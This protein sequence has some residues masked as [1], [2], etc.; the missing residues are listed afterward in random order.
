MDAIYDFGVSV[1]DFVLWLSGL[2]KT[3]AAPGFVVILLLIT[4]VILI[5]FFWFFTGRFC[6][7]VKGT[8]KRIEDEGER[9]EALSGEEVASLSSKWRPTGT[10]YDERLANA[11][12]EFEETLVRS[13]TVNGRTEIGNTV[14]P[15]NFFNLSDL[16][17]STGFWRAWP[18]VFVT[19]GLLLTFLG[20]IAALNTIGGDLSDDALS[21]LL[22][23]ASAKFI[24]SLTGL[25]CSIIF[26]FILR[27]RLGRMDGALHGLCDVIEKRLP[28]ISLEQIAK[29]Q[30]AELKDQSD[31]T[32]ALITELIAS[33]D[34]PLKTGLPNAIRAGISEA[35]IPVVEKIGTAGSDGVASSMETLSGQ[36]TDG[37]GD[38]LTQV[39]DRL[40][41]TGTTLEALAGRMD[42][43]SGRMGSEMERAVA[44]LAASVDEMRE[45][46]GAA[47]QRTSTSI[48]E[49]AEALFA[50]MRDALD[51]IQANTA[52][53]GA[54]MERAATAMTSAAGAFRS[55]IEAATTAGGMAARAA[56]QGAGQQAAASV[57]AAGEDV[58][59][60]LG[61]SLTAVTERAEGLG[62]KVSEDLLGPLD[63]MREGLERAA[64]NAAKGATE[65]SRFSAGAEAGAVAAREAADMVGETALA[66]GQSIVPIRET[67]TRFETAA[68]ETAQATSDSAR[69]MKIG[70]DSLV[71]SA[72]DALEAGRES[73][74][75]EQSAIA[76]DLAVIEVALER[77]EGI[78]GRFDTIDDKLGDALTRYRDEIEGAVANIGVRSKAIFDDH[79]RALDT[80]TTV[81][82]QTEAFLPHQK[83]S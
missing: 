62:A 4:L 1:K 38:A 13:S 44:R 64:E 48:N 30:L 71:K 9:G 76:A 22:T 73:L 35:M 63:R 32:R 50:G 18:G 25:F 34:E 82:S 27:W 24:M 37:I 81:V 43:S 67:A 56:L 5:A 17:V 11:W 80:L 3:D 53:N 45:S 28:Y 42:D 36:I 29:E 8:R 40:A 55:E 83:G 19:V 66:L 21:T 59:K 75:A 70:A 77:F 10:G 74:A 51:R 61:A 79:A 47:A 33:I 54:A 31:Q 72:Q 26:G 68:R 2:L 16:G 49:S 23:V 6:A 46:A 12:A 69:T 15:S 39:S 78:A 58:L 41:V 52:E 65:M 14:R 20:L 60:S 57:G 7:A